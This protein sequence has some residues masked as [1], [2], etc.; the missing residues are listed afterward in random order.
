[1]KLNVKSVV[2]CAHTCG[3]LICLQSVLGAEQEP[4]RS[5]LKDYEP[6]LTDPV[7]YPKVQVRSRMQIIRHTSS[8][9]GLCHCIINEL[10]YDLFQMLV[11]L[12]YFLPFYFVA[13]YALMRPGCAWL[14]DVALIHAGAA[15]QV[16]AH[17]WVILWD[18]GLCLDSLKSEL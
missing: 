2:T 7:A 18:L 8:A 6:Y 3:C 14:P 17:G 11:Y 15:I 4:M 16:R 12:F 5:F 1:M 10:L 13:I 9:P